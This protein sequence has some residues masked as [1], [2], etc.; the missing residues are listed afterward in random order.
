VLAG[1]GCLVNID[2]NVMLT[3]F[4]D[5][6][7]NNFVLT[8]SSKTPHSS[9]KTNTEH[10]ATHV[11]LQLRTAVVKDVNYLKHQPM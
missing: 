10:L 7:R 9:T 4:V 3:R 2:H 8:Q 1:A 5:K 6:T 11:V